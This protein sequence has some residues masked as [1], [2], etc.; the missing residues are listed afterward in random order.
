M[1][2]F[3]ADSPLAISGKAVI[4]IY[5]RYDIAFIRGYSKI[6]IKCGNALNG[7]FLCRFTRWDKVVRELYFGPMVVGAALVYK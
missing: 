5:A 1:L 6:W 7:E 4:I 3:Y 2:I